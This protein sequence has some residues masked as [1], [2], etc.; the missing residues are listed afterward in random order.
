MS[1]LGKIDQPNFIRTL[2]RNI[3][4]SGRRMMNFEPIGPDDLGQ[5]EL[6]SAPSQLYMVLHLFIFE[7]INEIKFVPNL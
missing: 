6:D 2:V 3:V 1:S 5:F 4:V 7:Y